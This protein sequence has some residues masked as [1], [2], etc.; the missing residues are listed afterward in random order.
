MVVFHHYPAGNLQ[1]ASAFRI[2]RLDA[3]NHPY[4][5]NNGG[6]SPRRQGDPNAPQNRVEYGG[7]G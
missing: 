2:H 3:L 6:K 4:C 7:G 5:E 1:A